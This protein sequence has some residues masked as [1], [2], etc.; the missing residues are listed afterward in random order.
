MGRGGFRA[1]LFRGHEHGA[2]PATDPGP[3]PK[4]ASSAARGPGPKSVN[5]DCR[6]GP[7]SIKMFAR[8]DCRG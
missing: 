8:L 6:F 3:G 4:L 2:L 7:S 1:G 5:L